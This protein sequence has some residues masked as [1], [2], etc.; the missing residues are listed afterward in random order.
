MDRIWKFISCKWVHEDISIT[1]KVC[2]AVNVDEFRLFLLIG[3]IE[4]IFAWHTHLYSTLN[5]E[6]CVPIT[7]E[8]P[9]VPHS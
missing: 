4:H 8:Q 6:T 1:L 5:L 7:T 9:T 2:G 3:A